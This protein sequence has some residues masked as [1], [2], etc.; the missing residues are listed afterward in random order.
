MTSP[1]LHWQILNSLTVIQDTHNGGSCR[2]FKFI[3]SLQHVL[4]QWLEMVCFV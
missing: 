1:T 4:K 2:I 3:T